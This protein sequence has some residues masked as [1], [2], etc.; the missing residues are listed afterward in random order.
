MIYAPS[1]P[2]FSSKRFCAMLKSKFPLV[3]GEERDR[4]ADHPYRPA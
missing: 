1:P 3:Q 4:L 2:V